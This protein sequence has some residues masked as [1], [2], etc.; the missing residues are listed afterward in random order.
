LAWLGYLLAQQA[1]TRVSEAGPDSAGW[2]GV[3]DKVVLQYLSTGL[4]GFGIDQSVG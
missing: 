2:L 4:A 1:G 3:A